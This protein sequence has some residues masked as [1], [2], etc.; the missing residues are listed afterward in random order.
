MICARFRLT[1]YDTPGVW[2]AMRADG[3]VAARVAVRFDESV[4]SLRLVG[5]ILAAMPD[6]DIAATLFEPPSSRLASLRRGLARPGLHRTGSGPD[7]TIGA[8]IRTTLL[9][10]LA[11]DRACG[12]RQHRS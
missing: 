2:R 7:G 3:D 6:G 11:G 10:E 12:H 8:A 1:P 9:A 5:A 4:E